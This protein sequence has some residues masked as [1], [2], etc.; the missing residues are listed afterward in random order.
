MGYRNPTVVSTV[1]HSPPAWAQEEEVRGRRDELFRAPTE[2]LQY[3]RCPELPYP[4]TLSFF[5]GEGFF[6][7]V[8]FFDGGCGSGFDAMTICKMKCA[9]VKHK[10]TYVAQ[11]VLL[12][13]RFLYLVSQ[14]I[15]H[16]ELCWRRREAT[17]L[18]IRLF[19]SP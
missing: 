1:F 7:G 12:L 2:N 14:L 4:L 6:T 9:G 18:F 15:G 5:F 8:A 3:T 11:L 10:T 19:L 13:L 16:A 17:S